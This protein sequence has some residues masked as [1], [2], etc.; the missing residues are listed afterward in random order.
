M[1][2]LRFSKE[3]L[4]NYLA[5]PD[6]DVEVIPLVRNLEYFRPSKPVD[7]QPV[8]VDKQA[9]RANS[10]HDLNSL[11]VLQKTHTKHKSASGVNAQMSKTNKFLLYTTKNLFALSG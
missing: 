8:S 2:V 6:F 9:A 1:E 7:P 4:G 10:Q 11:R 5:R 3:S